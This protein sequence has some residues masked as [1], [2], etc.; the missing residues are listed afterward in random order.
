[1]AGEYLAAESFVGFEGFESGLSDLG[2]KVSGGYC[3]LG[4]LGDF[5]GTSA[6]M[7]REGVLFFM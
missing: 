1:M 4:E 3:C 6:V 2:D 7:L 5:G